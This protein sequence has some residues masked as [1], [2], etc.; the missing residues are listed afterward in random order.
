M[1]QI[2]R[3]FYS[4]PHCEEE[5]HTF[6][7]HCASCQERHRQTPKIYFTSWKNVDSPL[8]RVH[9]DFFQYGNEKFLLYIDS[10]SKWIDV[11][12]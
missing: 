9:I 5:L 10:F 8:D 4:W 3:N 12:S 6:I 1:K 2:L 7:Q 11:H